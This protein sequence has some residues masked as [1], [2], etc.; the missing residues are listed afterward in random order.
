M[1]HSAFNSLEGD[2]I[3]IQQNELSRSF[4]ITLGSADAVRDALAFDRNSGLLSLNGAQ[5]A[6]T[7]NES[8]GFDINK[9][10]AIL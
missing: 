5:I 2:I 9:D 8:G 10:V 1:I 4:A 7:R 3:Q 6:L